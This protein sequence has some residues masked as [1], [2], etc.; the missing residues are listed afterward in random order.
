MREYFENLLLQIMKNNK[1]IILLTADDDSPLLTKIQ[2][3]FPERFIRVGIAECNLLGVAAG[4]SSLGFI[5]IVY[6]IGSFIIN[7]ALDFLR[8]DICINN[9]NVKLVGWGSGVKINNLGPTHHTTEDMAILRSLPNLTIL[10]PASMLEIEP[11][12]KAALSVESPVYIRMGKAFESEIFKSPPTFIIGKSQLLSKGK[13]ISFISTGNI[14][15]NVIAASNELKNYNIEADIINLS[16]IKPLDVKTI[17]KSIKKTGRVITVE[18]HQVTG[19]IGSAVAE[20]IAENDLTC[21]LIRMGLPD[22]FVTENGWYKD[23]IEQN[24]LDVK[25]IVKTAKKII[26]E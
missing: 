22:K 26:N 20:I 24:G 8:C 4:M 5:P 1:K 23:L 21:K 15:S 2:N 11:V 14:I 18:E 7:R 16:S 13:D 12:F 6:T 25:D 3:K 19:G 10:S 9:L 17:I